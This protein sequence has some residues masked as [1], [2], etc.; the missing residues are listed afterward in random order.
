MRWPL[1]VHRLDDEALFYAGELPAELGLDAAG[2]EA[3]WALHPPEFHEIKI[4]GRRVKTPRWQQAYGADYSYA[5]SLNRALPVPPALRPFHAWAREHIDDRLNGPLLNWYDGARGHYIGK[6][7]DSIANMTIGA[8][9]VTMSFG[10]GRTFRL[11]RW[12]GTDLRDFTAT[13]GRIFVMPF[14]TN[15]TWTHE[16]PRRA[17]QRGRRISL[18]F[19]AF[20]AR[21]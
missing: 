16:V 6:H 19:R 2:F 21:D 1:E 7:R 14:D 13:D 10:E 17:H 11:R 9:I 15:R 12:R 4:H 18:T 20:D 5:G 3:L 8:P